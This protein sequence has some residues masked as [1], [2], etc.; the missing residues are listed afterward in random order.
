MNDYCVSL[1]KCGH[2]W[3]LFLCFHNHIPLESFL[4]FSFQLLFQVN[5]TKHM[6]WNPK[7]GS[8]IN[9]RKESMHLKPEETRHSGSGQPGGERRSMTTNPFFGGKPPLNLPQSKNM[10]SI[11]KNSYAIWFNED[12]GIAAY[13][14]Y[15]VRKEDGMNIGTYGRGWKQGLVSIPKTVLTS[16]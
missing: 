15:R 1:H 13:S 12:S 10:K 3:C 7:A 5:Q 11:Q 6:A 9:G 16:F 4:V 2:T 14:A 8:P